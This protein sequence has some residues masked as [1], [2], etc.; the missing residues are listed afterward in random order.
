MLELVPILLGLLTLS[1]T[2]DIPDVTTLTP[3]QRAVYQGVIAEEFCSCDSAM[4]IGGCLELRPSCGV[5]RHFGDIAYTA[6]QSGNTT[7]EV[8]GFLAEQVIG[9]FCR[10]ASPLTV[11][12][13][14]SFGKSSAS[15]TIVEFADFRCGHCKAAA[16]LVK[17]AITRHSKNAR[18][19]F[20]P[21]PL[22]DHPESLAAAEAALAAGEQG[23]FWEM[24]DLLFDSQATGFSVEN[25]MGHA[26]ELGLNTK[27][28]RKALDT[29]QYRA[30][31]KALKK[32]GLD[33][34]VKGTPA[35]F[36]NG[37]RFDPSPAL[38]T[39]SRRID[40][41]LDRNRGQCQ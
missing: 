8:L 13:A 14:P 4:T 2:P 1:A 26:R 6:A 7:D 19:V 29:H 22:G 16:P 41:E 25:L 24:H 39:L 11:P 28:F 10:K 3:S 21:F 38:M 27:R 18:V 31:L 17:R 35:F 23:K 5:A 12:K 20:V 30:E 37:R 32:A 9:P 36:V 34:G 15:V 40:M 33:A